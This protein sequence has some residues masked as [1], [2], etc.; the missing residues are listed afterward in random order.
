MLVADR[1]TIGQQLR[2]QGWEGIIGEATKATTYKLPTKERQIEKR[3]L[4]TDEALF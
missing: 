3:E 1:K 4:E 2:R